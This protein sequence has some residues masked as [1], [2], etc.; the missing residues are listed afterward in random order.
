[1]KIKMLFNVVFFII[2][3]SNIYSKE[4][5]DYYPVHNK[6]YGIK[7]Y[8]I[9]YDQELIQ[10]QSDYY[11]IFSEIFKGQKDIN[12]IKVYFNK[13][14]NDDLI[15]I[16]IRDSILSY[17]RDQ[18]NNSIVILLNEYLKGNSKNQNVIEYIIQKKNNEKDL[19]FTNFSF[20]TLI[21]RKKFDYNISLLLPNTDWE[22]QAFSD[23]SS[24]YYL[25]GDNAYTGSI[26]IH[27][28]DINE[29]YNILEDKKNDYSRFNLK[30]N[31][32]NKKYDIYQIKGGK[33]IEIGSNI[34]IGTVIFK[35]IFE[36]IT[37]SSEKYNFQVF[38]ERNRFYLTDNKI[39][40]ISLN[41]I[42]AGNHML[43]N[44]ENLIYQ[45]GLL[46]DSVEFE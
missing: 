22:K 33:I 24:F 36:Q 11:T 43:A 41:S 32:N 44:R 8:N 6:Y 37:C 18:Y 39:Y 38:V 23:S 15:G 26:S 17:F 28:R 46:L 42:I 30:A 40:I 1:M 29:K 21:Y 12:E 20:S 10:F 14:S 5:L 45:K 4:K 2:L 7:E 35:K 27:C 19:I 25:A 3:I 9:K 31:T 13:I 34:K 16:N